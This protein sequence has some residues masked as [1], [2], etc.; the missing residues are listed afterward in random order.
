MPQA[1]W[2]NVIEA[3]SLGSPVHKV[4]H[5]KSGQSSLP[6]RHKQPRQAIVPGGEVAP[7]SSK[8]VAFDGVHSRV[9]SLQ[10]PDPQ[11]CPVEAHVITAEVDSLATAQAMAVHHQEQQ[12]V[13]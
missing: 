13:P 3:S 2:V 7:D 6:L 12:M 9:R 5:G 1:M 8:F 10:P 4:V 11:R